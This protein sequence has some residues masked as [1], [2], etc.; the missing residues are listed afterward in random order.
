MYFGN[1][2]ITRQ[3]FHSC[4]W[5]EVLLCR[6]PL[7]TSKHMKVVKTPAYVMMQNYENWWK[8]RKTYRYLHWW[9]N[10]W[11]VHGFLYSVRCNGVQVDVKKTT[12]SRLLKVQSVGR[13]SETK[14]I[15]RSS[16]LSGTVS[17]SGLL[18][19]K[20]PHGGRLY[21]SFLTE[22]TPAPP[23]LPGAPR[24]RPFESWSTPRSS[25][26][27]PRPPPPAHWTSHCFSAK[28]A[29]RKEIKKQHIL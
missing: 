16:L 5:G 21:L 25:G 7:F 6:F 10:T 24:W 27:S 23:P 22:F 19:S 8:C 18:F 11:E 17:L 26:Q 15:L 29:V 13:T 9:M 3:T 2:T 12:S 20:A 14:T 28:T 1:S 4:H